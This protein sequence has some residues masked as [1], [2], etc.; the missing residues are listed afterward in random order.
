VVG[1]GKKEESI[2]SKVKKR[3]LIEDQKE[4][5]KYEKLRA[6]RKGRDRGRGGGD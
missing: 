1:G 6:M 5:S 4:V 3:Y 2:E